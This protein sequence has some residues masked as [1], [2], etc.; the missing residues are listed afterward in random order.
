MN[1]TARPFHVGHREVVSIAWP[2]TLA[3]LSTPLLGLVDTGVVGRLGDP[4]LL[5]GLALGAI[6][7]DIVFTTFNFLRASTTALVSQAVGAE[8]EEQQRVVLLRAMAL[9]AAIGLVVLLLS[10]LILS[11]GL[12]AMESTDAVEGAVQDYFTIRIIS[13]PL[14]LLNYATLGW[15]LGQARAGVALFLQ[16]ILNGSNIV[17]SIYLGLHLGWGIEGVAW[18]TVIAEGLAVICGF[19]LIARSMRGFAFPSMAR[20][21]NPEA[22]KR[23]FGV[24][25]DIMIRSFCLLFAFAFFTTQGAKFGEE[26]LAANAVLM[27]FFLVS[28]YFLDGFATAAEQLA[29]RALGA[30]YRPAFDRSVRLTLIWGFVLAGFAT[31]AFFAGGPWLIDMLTTDETVREIARTYLPW[32]AMTALVG[33]V[34]FQMDGV[35]I[36]ATWSSDMR[37]MMILSLVVYLIVWWF[38]VPLM[39][40]HGLWLA[41]NV[42]LGVR[43]ITLYARLPVRRAQSFNTD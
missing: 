14:T 33:V 39:G 7:F 11:G 13:A 16:T 3:F 22:L 26:T 10:P 29:G 23:L 21:F 18:A 32:A 43:G 19:V 17:L 42:F 36:G 37:N 12:W 15:L 8:D 2:T 5:G 38:A 41:L 1:K 6:L 20:L 34:A 30:N 9:S 4:A 31:F 35:F 28:G 25:R 27:N 40:N 24:N